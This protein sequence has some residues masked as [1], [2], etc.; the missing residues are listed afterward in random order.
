L[1]LT[2]GAVAAVLSNKELLA[3]FLFSLALN[4]KQVLLIQITLHHDLLLKMT[5]SC[6]FCQIYK[7]TSELRIKSKGE[8]LLLFSV[9]SDAHNFVKWNAEKEIIFWWMFTC[10]YPYNSLFSVYVL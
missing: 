8:G 2:V 7:G 6:L 1:G 10:M 5:T 9:A 3:C 4:H